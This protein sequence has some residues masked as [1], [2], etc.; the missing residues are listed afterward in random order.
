ML[1]P[2]ISDITITTVGYCCY[3]YNCIIYNISK[4]VAINLLENSVHEDCGYI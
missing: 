3:I 1:C 2:N 4:S